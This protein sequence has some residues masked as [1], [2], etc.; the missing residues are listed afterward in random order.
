MR[1]SSRE[2][3]VEVLDA[4]EAG[5]KRAL[6]L[7]FD[8][9]TTPE[10]LRVLERWEQLRRWHPAVE[11]PLINQLAAQ[12]DATELGGKL[13]AALANRLRISRAEASR[14]IHEAADLGERRA[15][16]G[17]PLPPRLA[18]TAEGQRAG[19]IGAGHVAVI[20]GFCHRLPDV[21]DV[22]TCQQA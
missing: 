12:A 8:V 16:T 15:L 6:D 5:Y 19:D 3:I 14:R 7:T 10:R 9:L 21:V 22:E 17:E 2:E 13:P 20:R 4:L 18:A 1:S 11:H